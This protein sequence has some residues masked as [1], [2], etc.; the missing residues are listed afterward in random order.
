MGT[1]EGDLHFNA[2]ITRVKRKKTNINFSEV[3]K[4]RESKMLD[5]SWRLCKTNVV[6]L[7]H[8]TSSSH[9]ADLKIHSSLYFCRRSETKNLDMYR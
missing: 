3:L 8:L 9:F 1:L 5:P 4:N 6:I 2:T 7:C